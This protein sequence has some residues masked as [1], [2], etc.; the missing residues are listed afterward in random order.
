[1]Y[2]GVEIRCFISDKKLGNNG[3]LP[4]KNSVEGAKMSSVIHLVGKMS[5]KPLLHLLVQCLGGLPDATGKA[6]VNECGLEHFWES[7]VDIHYTSSCNAAPIKASE[8]LWNSSTRNGVAW[9]H[10]SRA[11]DMSGWGLS[12]IGEWRGIRRCKCHH[13]SGS[14]RS[15][16]SAVTFTH[17]THRAKP[18]HGASTTFDLISNMIWTFTLIHSRLIE[19]KSSITRTDELKGPLRLALLKKQQF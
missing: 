2:A 12:L 6:I 14:S 5:H 7:S 4:H 18:F 11:S 19:L 10:S 9:G 15:E 16:K 8:Q 1:M 17:R 13:S 3:G